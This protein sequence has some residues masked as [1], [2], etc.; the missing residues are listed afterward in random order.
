MDKLPKIGL[1]ILF[2]IVVLIILI[3]KST[4]TIDSGKAGVLYKTFSGGVVVD[5]P[6]LGEG[7]HL[8]LPWNRVFVYEVRQ[9]SLDENMQVLSSNGLEIRLDASIWFQPSYESLGLLHR[10]KGEN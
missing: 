1:P 9:Q 6:P 3:A 4:V 7:F 2:V 8:V 10:E 5:Q